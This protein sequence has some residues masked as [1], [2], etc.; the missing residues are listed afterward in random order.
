MTSSPVGRE[1][2]E[3][4]QLSRLV[5]SQVG[6]P[7]P[8][9]PSWRFVRYSDLATS[10]GPTAGKRQRLTAVT[11]V[12]FEPTFSRLKVSHPRPLDDDAVVFGAVPATRQRATGLRP[13]LN[14]S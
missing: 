14:D 7:M 1:G 4:S 12:G 3:P 2:I 13:H 9:L 5:Y 6:S 11:S 10:S 8:S